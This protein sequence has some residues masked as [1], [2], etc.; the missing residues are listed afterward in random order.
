MALPTNI[1][2]EDVA[3][4]I[5]E[6]ELVGMACSVDELATLA[7]VLGACSTLRTFVVMEHEGCA[8]P[9]LPA[10]VKQARRPCA[11]VQAP[12]ALRCGAAEGRRG[13]SGVRVPRQRPGEACGCPERV[14]WLLGIVFWNACMRRW[15]CGE[16]LPTEPGA[17][18]CQHAGRWKHLLCPALHHP[19]LLLGP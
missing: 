15:R 14:T 4:V 3:K 9:K 11:S 16:V 19:H 1:T 6:A 18:A 2:A 10:L 12:Q 5:N 17:V 8:N 7:P 13:Y